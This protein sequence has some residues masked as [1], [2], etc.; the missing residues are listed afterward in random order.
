[1]KIARIFT[2]NI[3][4]RRGKFNNV[5]QRIVNL[6]KKSELKTDSYVIQYTYSGLFR[7]IKN[8]KKRKQ[9]EFSMINGLALK[10]IWV[11]LTLIEYII[12][13]ILKMK[14][15]PCKGQLVK[16][17]PLFKKYDILLTH[18]L[19]STY[20]ATLVKENYDVPFV[21]TWHGS[22]INLY[23]FNNKKTFKTIKHF[24]EYSD[25]NFFVSKKLKDKSDEIFITNN[26][27]HLYSGP[28][29]LFYKKSKIEIIQIKERLNISSQYVVGF[30]GNMI[31]IK[32]I[33][34]LPA[35]MKRIKDDIKDVTFIMIGDGPLLKDLKKVRSEEHRVGREEKIRK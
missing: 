6:E 24:L 1:M 4:N 16:Y 28:S 32:N 33:K 10:N 35:I 27:S 3:E 11:H 23:P 8:I 22:D 12:V 5:Y 9:D 14:D 19:E 26:K 30:I 7:K 17:V 15:I 31:P 18:D 2:G 21:I 13:H 34:S 25:Y 20:V 29:S